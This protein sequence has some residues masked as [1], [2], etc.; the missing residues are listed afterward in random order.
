MRAKRTDKITNKMSDSLLDTR[1][2]MFCEDF[3]GNLAD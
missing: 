2:F 1:D 3:G